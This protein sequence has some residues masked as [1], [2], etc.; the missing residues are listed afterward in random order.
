MASTSRKSK[1]RVLT[2]SEQSR[3][4]A[5]FYEDIYQGER[6]FGDDNALS[7]FIDDND[8]AGNQD[9]DIE[10][11]M[12]TLVDAGDDD[13]DD[14]VAD[15]TDSNRELGKCEQCIDVANKT[16]GIKN[17]NKLNHRNKRKC[18]N[19]DE[20]VCSSYEGHCF[21]ICGKCVKL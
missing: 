19:C 16:K 3:L 4:L 14:V 11:A 20:F 13:Q 1:Q 6:N 9:D 17:V 7:N 12:E 21:Y 2:A 18:K 8:E 5:N 15:Q 10:F